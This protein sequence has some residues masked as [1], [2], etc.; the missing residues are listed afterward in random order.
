MEDLKKVLVFSAH[1][2]DLDFGCAGTVAK[3]TQ[4]G[5]TVVYCIITDGSKGKQKEEHFRLSRKQMA[6]IRKKE[7]K[8]AAKIAGVNKV[9]YLGEVDGELENTRKVRTKIA[10]AIR[11]EKPDAIFAFDPASCGFESFYR[12]HRDHRMGAEAVF[13]AIYPGAGSPSFFPELAKAG[14]PPH[15]IKAIWFYGSEKPNVFIDI[16]KTIDKKIQALVKHESQFKDFKQAAKF[17]RERAKRSG[18]KKKM[19]YAETFR[20]LSF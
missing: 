14:L 7:Q 11:E 18:K 2:D 9:T 13:D 10:K 1:P 12:C 17:I 15:Q 6:V 20:A 3:L 4:E 19:R 16:S 8:A 5:V